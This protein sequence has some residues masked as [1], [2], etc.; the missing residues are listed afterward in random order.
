[1]KN[2][3]AT[4]VQLECE[5]IDQECLVMLHKLGLVDPMRAHR[6]ADLGESNC[7]TQVQC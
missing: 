5:N 1:M 4:S 6:Y 3:N 7:R 2:S